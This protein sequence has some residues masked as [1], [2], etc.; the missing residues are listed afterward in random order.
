[1][2]AS[3]LKQALSPLQAPVGAI[4]PVLPVQASVP[5][6]CWR[7]VQLVGA[8]DGTLEGLSDGEVVGLDVDGTLEGLSDGDSEGEVDGTSLGEADGT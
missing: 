7:S 5:V 8:M 1:M 3:L 6:H 2:L 4:A